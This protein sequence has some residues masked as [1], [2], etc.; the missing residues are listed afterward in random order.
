MSSPRSNQPSNETPILHNDAATFQ[1][2]VTTAV[3]VVLANLNS[4]NT[5]TTGKGVDNF[6]CCIDPRSQKMITVTDLQSRKTKNRKKKRQAQIRAPCSQLWIRGKTSEASR[7]GVQ[8][9][10]KTCHATTASDNPCHPSTDQTIR[11]KT[12]EV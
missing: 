5:N 12:S 6:N 2:T 11:G 3:T 10:P 4:G 9:I 8:A 7:I 1:V